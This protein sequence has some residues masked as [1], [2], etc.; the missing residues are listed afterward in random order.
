MI[1]TR[2][3]LILFDIDGTLL[4]TPGVGRKATA[5][6]MLE[7]YG[8]LP[9]LD[10]HQFSGKTD[11]FTLTE[12]LAGQGFDQGAVAA[13]LDDFAAAMG[14]YTSI[15]AQEMPVQVLPGALEA[16]HRLRG[17]SSSLVGLVTGNTPQ[18]SAAK[19]RAAGFDPDWFPVGAY[20][21]E[22][23]DRNDLPA[24]AL[25]RAHHYCGYPIRSEQAYVIGDTVMDIACARAVG[26]VAIAVRNGFGEVTELEQAAPDYLLDDLTQLFDVL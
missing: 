25:E 17:D 2:N 4:K 22:S 5:A 26:A 18:S 11:Y 10:L 20:G 8:T 23:V 15:Y 16:V 12:L 19:L 1:Q 3:R 6:A 24:Y 14:H 9:D 7:V 21:T 13:R